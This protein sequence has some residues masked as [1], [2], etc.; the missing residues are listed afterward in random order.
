[1]RN[2]EPYGRFCKRPP[3]VRL[4]CNANAG[5]WRSV[6][7][8]GPRLAR[9]LTFVEATVA[10]TH[11][12]GVPDNDRNLDE[13]DSEGIHPSPPEP[14]GVPAASSSIEV[15]QAVLTRRSLRT[16]ARRV[17]RAVRAG[18][19]SASGSA[20]GYVLAPCAFVALRGDSLAWHASRVAN[21]A[22]RRTRAHAA[23]VQRRWTKAVQSMSATSHLEAE[24]AVVAAVLAV[25]ALG[26]GGLLLTSWNEP[27]HTSSAVGTLSAGLVPARASTTYVEPASVATAVPAPLGPP[28]ETRLRPRVVT[29]SSLNTILRRNDTRSLQHAF[30]N[31]RRETLAFHRCGMRMTDAD[32]AV[33]TCDGGVSD[34]GRRV[35]WTI[36]FQRTG[37][38]WTVQRVS[39][40]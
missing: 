18:L 24:G 13:F 2:V 28:T 22:S 31:L 35:R 21:D 8:G 6:P 33:A 1:M 23:V 29:A 19:M 14:T 15:A 20:V 17:G 27:A 11:I 3:T 5:S 26:Y 12:V 39:G 34:G 4:R 36:D 30:D 25:V 16:R 9:L 32:R 10:P 37:R 38:R 7:D 40:R